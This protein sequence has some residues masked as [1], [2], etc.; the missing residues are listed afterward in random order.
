MPGLSQGQ[1]VSWNILIVM[2]V[3]RGLGPMAAKMLYRSPGSQHV[4]SNHQA[5][6]PTA[7][8]SGCSG[9][10]RNVR[11]DSPI[12]LTS[13][14]SSA[15]CSIRGVFRSVFDPTMAGS[16]LHWQC[17]RGLPPSALGRLTSN[18]AVYGKSGNVESFNGAL[19]DELLNSGIFNSRT[20]VKTMIK[21]PRSI[22]NAG[23][24]HS[25]L[26]YAPPS[27]EAISWP[28]SSG[29]TPVT[30]PARTPVAEFQHLS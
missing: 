11:A 15:I 4:L 5:I 18:P 25:S 24:N 19:C 12:S 13:S 16:T 22:C 27:P 23:Q 1:I 9:A 7:S 30:R 8:A 21:Q 2:R 10:R 17:G 6:G 29:P 20:G 3:W 26:G 14:S 28:A